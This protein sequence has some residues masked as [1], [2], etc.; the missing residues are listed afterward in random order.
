MI[1]NKLL[2]LW[3]ECEDKDNFEAQTKYNKLSLKDKS[4]LFDLIVANRG[5]VITVDDRED[6]SVLIELKKL[7]I[8][9]ISKR[10][11]TGDYVWVKGDV[12]IERKTINDFCTSVMDKRMEN[13]AKRMKRKYKH[14]YVLISGRIKD[15]ISPIHDNAI[16]GMMVSLLVKHDIKVLC[17]DDDKQ[18]A[19]AM[20]R[21]FERHKE[22]KGGNNQN[23]S[24]K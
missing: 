6:S 24:N 11:D 7:G 23:A 21:I 15:R 4:R 2:Q 17:V 20:K 19:F 3:E 18:L 1:D 16:V 10:I 8:E 14:C 5:F 12:C 13:Q 22:M 9:C